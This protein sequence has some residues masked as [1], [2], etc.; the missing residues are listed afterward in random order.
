MQSLAGADSTG[1][2]T[3]T[4]GPAVA[5]VFFEGGK[6]VHCESGQLI[7]EDGVLE[8]LF[9]KE[10]NFNFFPDQKATLQTVK[11]RLEGMLMESANLQ[12]F[13]TFL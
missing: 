9:W 2:L 3:V 12:D 10:G 11:R 13:T 6:L 5:I 1:K 8:L 7:G 4:R